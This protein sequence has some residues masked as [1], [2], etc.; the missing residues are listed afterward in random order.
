MALQSLGYRDIAIVKNTGE[1]EVRVNLQEAHS[2]LESL[3]LQ[4]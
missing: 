4:I 2:E 3:Q 1:K